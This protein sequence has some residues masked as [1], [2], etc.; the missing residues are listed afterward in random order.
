MRGLNGYK[1]E[2]IPVLVNWLLTQ[3]PHVSG[4]ASEC[5]DGLQDAPPNITIVG[6]HRQR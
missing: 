6:D 1:P 3:P 4:R 5:L 2:G